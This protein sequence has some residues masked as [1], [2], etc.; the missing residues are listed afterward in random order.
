MHQAGGK[1]KLS[2]FYP[3]TPMRVTNRKKLL[4]MKQ[5]SFEIFQSASIKNSQG[6]TV[7]SVET[8][9]RH[10]F[11]FTKSGS[12]PSLATGQQYRRS[13]MT[14]QHHILPSLLASFLALYFPCS[15]SN[16]R[17]SQMQR[18]ACQPL[19]RH[20]YFKA[21]SQTHRHFQYSLCIIQNLES[22]MIA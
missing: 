1:R 13:N 18:A 14:Q 7:K 22:R 15:V 10:R 20:Y 3:W 5:L 16:V 12:P 2:G 17:G 9:E 6:C 8:G 19:V 11:Y 21:S 4:N